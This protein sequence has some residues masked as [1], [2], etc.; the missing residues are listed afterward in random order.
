M[1]LC[2]DNVSILD[3]M[4]NRRLGPAEVHEKFG[5]GPERVGDVL[6]LMGDSIDNVPGVAGIGPKTAAE[7]INKYGTLD[8]LLAAAPAR[9][10][11]SAG[12]R[13][14][15]R[16]T[17][18]QVARA[19]AAARRRAAAEDA[20]R[21]APG[22]ARPRA[23]ARAVPRAG[24]LAPGRLAVAPG[25]R[26][27]RPA[28][29]G[30]RRRPRCP[31][32]RRAR[33]AGPRG[34]AAR[35]AHRAGPRRPGGARRDIEAAGA[36]ALAALYDGPRRCG[37]ISSGSG[38]AVRPPG[39]PPPRLRAALPPLPGRARLPAR[40]RGPGG[41]GALL[42]SPRV[43]KH[44]HDGKTMEVLLRRRDRLLGGVASDSMLAAYLL[45]ACRAPLRP[46]RRRETERAGEVASRPSWMGTGR[47]TRRGRTSP[48]RRSGR[49]LGA[50]PPRR[51][52][53]R[54]ARTRS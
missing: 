54:R 32:R 9:S 2:D 16:E 10:R 20:G 38:F 41:A 53:S 34:A 36:V 4:K 3:T 48:S 8:E 23:A 43:A 51:W 46:G 33:N 22:R 18:A 35:R 1:Q 31:R 24:V 6:A 39:R 19:R 42:A 45:D 49:R 50:R 37:R 17:R 12:T 27:N 44:V 15:R 25:R 30:A 28:R 26:G 14:R 11:A 52:R 47:A 40:G 5:V 29:R 13:S 21:A 7:L